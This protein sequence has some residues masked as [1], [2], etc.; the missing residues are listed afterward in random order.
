[1]ELNESN[2]GDV[3]V[4]SISAHILGDADS[5]CLKDKV[6]DLISQG[7]NKMVFDMKNVK[8]INSIGIGILMSC[9]TSFANVDGQLKLVNV[10]E[11]VNS[12]LEITELDQFFHYHDSIN[13]AMTNFQSYQ[14]SF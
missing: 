4:L 8:L 6:K 10:G 2:R 7:K 9:W 1:M 13:E 12:L 3:V 11:R 14:R 5:Q